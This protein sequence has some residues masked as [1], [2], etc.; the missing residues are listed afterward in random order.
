MGEMRNAYILSVTSEGKR[1]FGRSRN[2]LGIILKWI[3]N[4]HSG[5]YQNGFIW[6]RKGT[7]GRLVKV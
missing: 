3:F 5:K 6:L 1:P 7:G 2:R 4:K